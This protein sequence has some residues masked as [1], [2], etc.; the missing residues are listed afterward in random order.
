MKIPSRIQGNSP[1]K[2]KQ[3]NARKRSIKEMVNVVLESMV[4]FLLYLKSRLGRKCKGIVRE[5]G[6]LTNRNNLVGPKNQ[7]KILLQ[8]AAK[9]HFPKYLLGTRLSQ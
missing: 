2:S 1:P 7:T 6:A 4:T 5:E 3:L 8:A 9:G